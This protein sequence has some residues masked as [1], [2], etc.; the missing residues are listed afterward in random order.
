[1]TLLEICPNLTYHAKTYEFINMFPNIKKIKSQIMNHM[2]KNIYTQKL[3]ESFIDDEVQSNE[4]NVNI[5]KIHKIQYILKFI[6]K[7]SKIFP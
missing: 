2:K 4:H 7:K 5:K 1:M 3:Q 6:I